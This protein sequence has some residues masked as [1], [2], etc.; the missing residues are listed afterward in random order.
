M[1]RP[2]RIR[3]RH[4]ARNPICPQA[5]G[6]AAAAGLALA[7]V[8]A[9]VAA[10]GAPGPGFHADPGTDP[11]R[12]GDHPA[13]GFVAPG[14]SRD[15]VTRNVATGLR[16]DKVFP[17][18]YDTRALGQVSPVK[19]QGACG[20]C[21]AFGTAADLESRLLMDGQGLFDISE[22]NLKECHYQDNSCLGG[23]QY[24]TISHITRAGAVLESCDPYL[25]SNSTC[26]TGCSA[27][28]TVTSWLEITGNEVP[29]PDLLKQY[30]MDHGPLQTTVFAGDPSEPAFTA[31]FNSYDGSGALYFTGANLPN[32][33]VFLVGWD[34][35][36][37][38]P[39]GTG[40]WIVKNSWGTSW[41]GTCG[42]GSERG[43]FYI[44]YGSASI[45]K[46]SSVIDGFM[47]TVETFSVLSNDEGGYNTGFGGMGATLW[48]LASLTTPT[49]NYLHRVEFFTTDTTTDVDVFV[50]GTFNGST[51]SN[52]LASSL[53][54]SFAEPGYHYVQLDPLLE[55]TAGQT[56][57]VAVKFSNQSYIYPLAADGEGPADAGRSYLSTN[58]SS[59][60]SMTTYGVETTIR[61]RVSTD[62]ALG[63]DD[64]GQSPPPAEL[65]EHLQL[66]AAYPNP[67]NPNTTIEYTLHRSGPVE[68]RIHD[69]KGRVVRDLVVEVREAGTHEVIWDGRDN[70]GGLVPSGVYFCRAAADQQADALK[71]VLL[72]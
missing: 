55:L 59:W 43:Y 58:G 32:H 48:G 49:D 65:P 72:K 22:N 44:A 21:Y 16:P 46:Y 17:A 70:T 62:T 31:Q 2:A 8:L 36:I 57:H 63:V 1:R 33:S 28:F 38:H 41:G 35:G 4:I 47:N 19:N 6:L 5:P 34:D 3:V 60:L 9:S 53:N 51:T 26:N 15:H 14:F 67:F 56:I 45:G 23:N 18:A 11:G 24:H 52:L 54:H 7:L 10:Q 71:L 64:P 27:P 61:A 12:S 37:A 40:A 50:Y 20:A 29:D 69:L 25:A 30:L 68:L 13:H 39:G 66:K 42:Y